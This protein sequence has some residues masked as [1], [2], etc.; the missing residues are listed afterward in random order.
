MRFGARALDRSTTLTEVEAIMSQPPRPGRPIVPPERSGTMIEGA[1][2]A[3][4]YV[5]RSGT[6]LETDEDLR[7]AIQSGFKAHPQAQPAPAPASRPAEVAGRAANLFRPTGRPPVALLT[8]YDD[9][10]TEGEVIRIREPRFVIGRTEG[11][12]RIPIDGRIS[13]KHVEITLQTVGGIHRWVVTDLQSTHGMYVRV[14]RTVLADKAE[15]LVGNGRYRL[16]IPEAAPDDTADFVPAAANT[17]ETRGW[18]AGPSPFRPPAL[19]ELIGGEIGNRLLLVKEEYWIG[20]DPR[21]ASDR[22]ARRPVLR[23]EA[24]PPLSGP[25]G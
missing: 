15:F 19:T 16:D 10:K 17:G 11:D 14:T 13:S 5:E 8:V 20:T 9:G 25:A 2:G 18:D 3:P 4:L 12:L 22:P 23:A 24:R 1:G 7:Q 6:V 21:P